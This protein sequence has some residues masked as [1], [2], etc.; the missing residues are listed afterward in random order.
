SGTPNATSYVDDIDFEGTTTNFEPTP[1]AQPAAPTNLYFNTRTNT[2][3][4]GYATSK[5]YTGGAMNLDWTAVTP[6]NEVKEYRI[7]RTYPNGTISTYTILPGTH[8][9]LYNFTQEGQGWYKYRV[10]AESI[11]GTN[12]WSPWSSQV[13]INYDTT[14]PVLTINSPS[15]NGYFNG[16]NNV[17]FSGSYTDGA[18]GSGLNRIHVYVSRGNHYVYQQYFLS[19]YATLN[20]TNQTWSFTLPASEIKSLGLNDG[21]QINFLAVPFDNAG[22][23]GNSRAYQRYIT[24]DNQ[25]PTVTFSSPSGNYMNTTKPFTIAGT[26]TEHGG[27]GISRI[28][29]YISKGDEYNYNAHVGYL[30]A[31]LPN[32]PARANGA[33]GTFTYT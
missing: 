25:A 6:N 18:N 20:T 1:P 29:L 9:P 24:F 12:N 22:N 13:E 23:G 21:D 5:S 2:Y 10:Q 27:S 31:S 4:S 33:T 17:T 30:T 16:G 26:Y 11:Y 28:Q 15:V 14:T 8:T 19:G 7:E 3:Q 32:K